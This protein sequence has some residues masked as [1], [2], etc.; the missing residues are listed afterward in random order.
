[1]CQWS[2]CQKQLST[3]PLLIRK[4]LSSHIKPTTASDFDPKCKWADCTKEKRTKSQLVSHLNVHLDIRPFKC[5]LCHK[6][7]KRKNDVRVHAKI[8]KVVDGMYAS[9]TSFQSIGFNDIVGEL[10]LGLS[11]SDCS[12]FY[13][14]DSIEYTLPMLSN[15][16]SSLPEE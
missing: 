13:T 4:H 16:T 8:C 5:L 12:S 14:N 2:N 7:F 10:F 11:D 6:N 1:M 15:F 9:D 3:E